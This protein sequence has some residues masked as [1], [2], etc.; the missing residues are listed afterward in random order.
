VRTK[1]ACATKTPAHLRFSVETRA[2][3]DDIGLEYGTMFWSFEVKDKK[4]S[5]E[6]WSVGVGTSDTF[7]AQKSCARCSPAPAPNPP[8][9]PPPVRFTCLRAGSTMVGVPVPAK[10]TGMNIDVSV[11]AT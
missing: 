3:S 7:D 10:P 6:T 9:L 8:Q 5:N 4:V 2:R 1:K 11:P